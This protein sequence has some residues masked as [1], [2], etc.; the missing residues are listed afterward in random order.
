MTTWELKIGDYRADGAIETNFLKTQN[1]REKLF[2]I[3][4]NAFKK[5]DMLSQNIY[6]EIEKKPKT[7]FGKQTNKFIDK[8]NKV[9]KNYE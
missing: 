8:S 6:K 4:K 9:I 5:Y 2:K 3:I 1:G 7:I